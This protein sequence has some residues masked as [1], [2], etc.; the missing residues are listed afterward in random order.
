MSVIVEDES[1]VTTCVKI[2]VNIGETS[3]DQLETHLT[4][5]NRSFEHLQEI[6]H[7]FHLLSSTQ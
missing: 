5:I 4:T 6:E 3:E 2:T 7:K 1:S